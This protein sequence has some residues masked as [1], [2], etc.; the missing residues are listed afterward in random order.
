MK[1]PLI[2]CILDGWGYNPSSYGNAIE[3]ARTPVWHSLLAKYPHNLLEASDTAVGLPAGQ[4]GNSEVGH[5]N[6]GAGR[7]VMQLLG[8]IEEAVKNGTLPDNP[9]LKDFIGKLKK[10]GGTCHIWGLVSNGGVHSHIDHIAALMKVVAGAGVPVSL[11]A[12]TDGRDVDPKS[13]IEFLSQILDVIKN[14][15]DTRLA[16]LSGRYYAMDRNKT[17][18]R[19]K[20]AY[21]AMVEAKGN[22]FDNAIKALEDSY[23]KGITDEFVVPSVAADYDGMKDGDGLLLANFRADRVREIATALTD[24]NFADFPRDKVINFSATLGLAEYSEELSA[25]FDTIFPPQKLTNI[26]GEVLADNGLTQLRIAET[27]KY[28]HVTF[29][30]NGGEEKQF[31]G[32]ERILIPSPAVATYDLKPEMSSAEITDN[33][34]ESVASGKFDVIIVNYANGDMV[35]HTGM[36]DAAEK[37]AVAIDACL[38]RLEKLV[39]DAQGTMIITADH[40]NCE[41][42]LDKDGNPVTSHTTN[43]VE[44]VLIGRPE[45]KE[46]HKGALC[47]I[48]PTILKLLNLPQPSEMTGKALF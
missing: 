28:A 25:S 10:S 30:F 6:I 7:V 32:E 27:E 11:H 3:L 15:P 13:G 42:M 14:T 23:A 1:K 8:S 21:D 37:A 17:W 45:V 35:G 46:L 5:T 43:P 40:G 12:V 22:R 31:P 19:V 48:A 47:D 20:L 16:T 4:M 33:I 2:L 34:E 39:I 18:D 41:V 24:K 36:L 26:L 44:C 38:A 29:F 9:Q